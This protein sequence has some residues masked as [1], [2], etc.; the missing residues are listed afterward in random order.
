MKYHQTGQSR[1]IK[2]WLEY[3][4]EG[5]SARTWAL[6]QEILRCILTISQTRQPEGEEWI[7][8]T[9]WHNKKILGN[10]K[11]QGHF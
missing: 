9:K 8:L 11:R 7:Y 2:F 3:P 1:C 10:H 6:R 4:R 5:T